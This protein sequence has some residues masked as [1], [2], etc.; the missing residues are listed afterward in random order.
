MP[1]PMRVKPG[2]DVAVMDFFPAKP[3]P[4][5]PVMAS[6]SELAW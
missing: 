2:P 4:T 6:I 3:A 5:M 1:S